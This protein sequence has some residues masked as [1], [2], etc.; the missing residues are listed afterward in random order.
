[1]EANKFNTFLKSTLETCATLNG[2]ERKRLRDKLKFQDTYIRHVQRFGQKGGLNGVLLHDTR[3]S[4]GIF[5]PL[6]VQGSDN[7]EGTTGSD[8]PVDSGEKANLGGADK[9]IEGR[10]CEATVVEGSK[11]H[12]GEGQATE[13]KVESGL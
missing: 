2:G 13:A 9:P 12:G 1:M 7:G 3:D 8:A 11:C 6:P 10:V 5:Q 4:G